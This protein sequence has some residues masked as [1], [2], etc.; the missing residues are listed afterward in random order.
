DDSATQADTTTAELRHDELRLS[1]APT[2]SPP[3][4]EFNDF[5]RHWQSGQPGDLMAPPQDGLITVQSVSDMA[6]DSPSAKDDDAVA[7]DKALSDAKQRVSPLE[8]N[9]KNLNQ[10]LQSQGSAAHEAVLE[11]AASLRQSFGEVADAVSDVAQSIEREFSDEA[12]DDDHT[13]ENG[14]ASEVESQGSLEQN[15]TASATT[16]LESW[17]NKHMNSVLLA[18]LGIIILL[19]VWIL[20]LLSRRR[21]DAAKA[22]TPEMVQEKLDQINLDLQEPTVDSS[23]KP[24]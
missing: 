9:V 17:I 13:T 10:A 8:E 7:T 22:I 21:H 20:R 5:E 19:L 4:A 16:K 14:I 23:Q 1:R 15:T 24:S 12:T 11:G 3:A 18:G 6:S 2:A